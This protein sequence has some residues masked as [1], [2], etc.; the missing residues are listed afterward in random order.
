[1]Q[2]L[3]ILNLESLGHLSAS[4]DVSGSIK[5]ELYLAMKTQPQVMRLKP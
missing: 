3:K 2:T 5:K 1:M 4:K